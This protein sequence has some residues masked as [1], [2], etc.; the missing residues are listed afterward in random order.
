MQQY[1]VRRLFLVPPVLVLLSALVFWGIRMIPGDVVDVRLEGA[2]TPEK[3]EALRED[4]GL[5]EP[6]WRAYPAWAVNALRGDLGRSLITDEPVL[7]EIVDRLPVTFELVLLSLLIQLFIG[8]PLGVAAAVN[9][10]KLIDHAILLLS[11][12]ALAV[13]N[14]WVAT[15]VLTFP[16]LW[17][18]WSPPFGYSPFF[19]DPVRNIQQFIIPASIIGLF[20]TAIILRL[21]RAQLIEVLRHDYVTTARAKGL[22]ERTVVLRHALKNAMIP[23]VTV[24]GLAMANAIAGAVIVEQ[25]FALPGLGSYGVSAIVRRDYTSLQGFAL[26]VGCSYVFVNLLVDLV[27][28]YLDPRIRY[29]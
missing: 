27:Y 5:N 25:I 26:V 13:P 21:T 2:G 17:W 10:G 1:V 8:I 18:H 24:L 16:S 14:F 29:T 7:A 6:V 4:L 22:K 3:A 28:G 23:V 11:I 15:L 20:L 9:Q 12:V 19:D